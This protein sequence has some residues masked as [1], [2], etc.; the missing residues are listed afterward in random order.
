MIMSNENSPE[1]IHLIHDIESNETVATDDKYYVATRCLDY[2]TLDEVD[3]KL[4]KKTFVYPNKDVDVDNEK[5]DECRKWFISD[6]QVEVR[7]GWF[8]L[9]S[10]IK[11][12]K[13]VLFKQKYWGRYLGSVE[14][15]QPTETRNGYFKVR[16][17]S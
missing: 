3:D 2:E 9:E 11:A 15:V 17:S 16:I 10:L 13:E 8:H 5:Y 14:F 4:A 12:T 7:S 6:T 1:E